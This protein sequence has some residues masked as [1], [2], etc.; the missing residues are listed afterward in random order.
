MSAT[1]TKY[2]LG[3]NTPGGFYSLYDG[4]VD[5]AV[6]DT[7]Y[8]IKGGPG[9]GK[10][11]FMNRIASE[12]ARAGKSVEYIHC[13]GDPD[14]LDAVYFPELRL[15]YV[16]GSAPHII[17]PRYPGTAERFINLGIYYD[18][19]ALS[20]K[21]A[22]IVAIMTAYKAAYDR[23]YSLISAAEATTRDMYLPLL[24]KSVKDRIRSRASGIISREIRGTGLHG[25]VKKRFLGALT[26]SGR[27]T[28]FDTVET[29]AKCV[30]AIDNEYGFAPIL[31]SAIADA[32]KD[33]NLTIILCPNP[34]C[35]DSAEHLLIPELSLAFVSQTAKTP[36][37]GEIY[38]HLR[39]DALIDIHSERAMRSGLRSCAKIA[40]LL[41]R[42]AI[43]KLHEARSLH[44]D[45]EAVYNPHVEFEGVYSLADAHIAQLDL[46]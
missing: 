39:L 13:S 25:E 24:T 42:E 46:P 17:E 5:T 26:C 30:Y 1:I 29:L 22:E 7:L 10:S 11:S 21:R 41:E 27:I 15:G 12:L 37:P 23:A 28:F 18:A 6:K 44:D 36:Y 14:S 4:F 38:R 32:A 33:R 3:A 40:S 16:D 35:P 43:S 45:L 31:L 19:A 8:I 20:K 9:C 34:I 2:F